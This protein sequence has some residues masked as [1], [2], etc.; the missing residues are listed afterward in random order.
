M[1]SGLREDLGEIWIV[2]VDDLLSYWNSF[3]AW[4][5]LPIGREE[6]AAAVGEG[7]LDPRPYDV[8]PLGPR[9]PG[10]RRYHVERIAWLVVHRDDAPICIDVGAP[11]LG[12]HPS[13]G[14]FDFIDGNHRVCAA[15]FRTDETI[16]VSYGGECDAMVVLFPRGR[17]R[18]PITQSQD[19]T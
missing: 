2:P 19:I 15:A 4:T 9:D 14:D 13:H 1:K 11:S 18:K 5:E 3:G 6:I 17:I 12:W 7:R 16:L 10:F 8:M